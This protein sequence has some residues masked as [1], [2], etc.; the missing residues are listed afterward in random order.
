MRRVYLSNDIDATDCGGA[1]S[2]GAPEPDGLSPDFVRALI[3]R[4]GAE[5]P[6]LGAD[7]VEVA[8]PIGSADDARRTAEVAASYMLDSLAALAARSISYIAPMA[9][10]PDDEGEEATADPRSTR[11]GRRWRRVTSRRRGG[12]PRRSTRTR[13]RRCCCSRPVSAKRGTTPQAVAI[14][15]RAMAADPEWATPEL[16]MA[17]LLAADPETTEEALTTPSGRSI[18]PRRR[19]SSSR[20]SRSRPA[21]RW[22]WARPTRRS[23]RCPIC[24]RPRCGSTICE[25][26]LEIAD[27]HLAVGDRRRRGRACALL[28]EASP[29]DGRR[30]VRAR[31]RG[32]GARRRGGDA[33]GLEA[34]LDARRRAPAL[35]SRRASACSEA[36]VAAVAEAALE[37]LPERARALLAGIPIVIAELPAEVD[38]DGG[39]DPR[40]LGLFSGTAYSDGATGSAASRG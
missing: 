8:P 34:R 7:V 40:A 24:R 19:T 15:R 22:S 16:W 30:L 6:L 20:R 4:V 23:R 39:L 13:P 33:R 12:G 11:P 3:A 31:L 32:R 25:L 1:P 17:E 5:F 18:W 28:C 9:R 14:L 29:A 26:A 2:T 37:E 10:E 21:S 38:V 27:L 36:E 35:A